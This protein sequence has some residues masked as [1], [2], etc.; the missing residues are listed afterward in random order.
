MSATAADVLTRGGSTTTTTGPTSTTT[1]QPLPGDGKVPPGWYDSVKDPETKAWLAT[2][3]LPDA[4]S[5]L[6]SYWGL[7]RLIGADKAG[8]TLMAP[9]DD[10]DAEA[11]GTLAKRLGLPEKPDDYKLPL[12]DGADPEF[13]KAAA[14]AFHKLG[15]PPRYGKGI[16][17]WWNGYVSSEMA[18]QEQ[19][20]LA[21]AAEQ[22]AKVMTEW[23][24]AATANEELS[25]RGFREFA[26]QF[27]LKQKDGKDDNDLIKRFQAVLGADTMLK[28]F[29]GLGSMNA[30]SRFAGGGGP[31]GFKG[32]S[33]DIQAQI[34]QITTDRMAGKINDIQWRQE[35][36]PRMLELF[37]ALGQA[38]A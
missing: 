10:A 27:G 18:K 2:K 38:G 23:G 6:K 17:E 34:N 15:I 20:D 7:E 24:S 16:T 19:A 28:F 3:G 30:E 21:R 9:K 12:P 4:E 11:W 22:T 33:N 8:R 25:R 32:N 14:T 1:S 37:K 36:E 26:E 35:F 31:S 5:A 13:A 29:H